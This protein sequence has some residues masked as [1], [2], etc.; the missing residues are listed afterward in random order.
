MEWV[1][2]LDPVRNLIEVWVS[3][4]HEPRKLRGLRGSG[5]S[6]PCGR[7]AHYTHVLAAEVSMDSEPDWTAIEQVRE[8]VAA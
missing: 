8:R 1:Y 3:A 4:E 2:V 6:V 5:R 7:G